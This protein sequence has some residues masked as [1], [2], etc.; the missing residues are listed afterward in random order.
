MSLF[1]KLPLDI[2]EI[3]YKASLVEHVENFHR[4]FIEFHLKC[5]R[6]RLTYEYVEYEK[7]EDLLTQINGLIRIVKAL[8][9]CP[10]GGSQTYLQKQ[11]ALFCAYNLCKVIEL[12]SKLLKQHGHDQ[13]LTI[14]KDKMTDIFTTM[15]II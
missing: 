10:I 15:D 3:I 12:N 8:Q 4:N 2:T 13:F 11:S 14:A 9:L 1:D 7:I 6:Q 5:A